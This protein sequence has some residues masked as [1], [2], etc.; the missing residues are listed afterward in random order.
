[1]PSIHL[2][3]DSVI[4]KIAAGEVVDRPASVIRELVENAIDSGATSITVNITDGGSNLIQVSDNG[5]GMERDD[6]VMSIERHATSK[7]TSSGDLMKIST[8]G[9]RGE[10]LATI[11][12]VSKL[13]IIT[14]K[15]SANLGTDTLGTVV[16]IQ[17]GKLISVKD[18]AAPL[19]TEIT[20][21]NL[22]FNTPARKKFLKSDNIETAKIKEWLNSTALAHPKVS[23]KFIVDGTDN[24]FFQSEELDFARMKKLIKGSTVDI[25]AAIPGVAIQGVIGHPL[26]SQSLLTYVTTLV[27][28]RVVSDKGVVR[29]LRDGFSTMLKPG[30]NPVGVINIAVRPD[31]V[32]VNVHP[33]KSEVRFVDARAVYDCIRNAVS[34]ALSEIKSG[35]AVP[36]QQ[37]Q[38]QVFAPAALAARKVIEKTFVLTS[39]VDSQIPA[40]TTANQS[41]IDPIINILPAVKLESLE[42]QIKLSP[43]NTFFSS[44]R[45]IGQLF[46]CY[47]LCE[48]KIPEVEKNHPDIDRE[49]IIVDMHAAHERVNFNIVRQ[50]LLEKKNLLSQRLL[51]PLILSLSEERIS[52]LEEVKDSILISGFEFQIKQ[53]QIIFTAIP[54]IVPQSKIQE[55]ILSI[56]NPENLQTLKAPLEIFIDELAARIACHASVRSGDSMLSQ[57]AYALFDK[58]DS[59]ECGLACPHGRPVYW[60]CSKKEVEQWFGR[61]EA[62]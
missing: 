61:G 21:R 46:S 13:T 6:A 27:N 25:N 37:V 26:T 47:L 29:A 31:L 45:Y 33:Q 57:E 43:K 48:R 18:A 35:S 54:S 55:L 20:V 2:L 58:L 17:G 16:L 50:R 44:L 34:A 5:S 9:F 32:D 4:N 7:I 24:F 59:A 3:S 51:L 62:R 10:A 19:G 41:Y 30:E 38:K 39:K 28:G 1:M 36:M 52:I 14:R 15:S 53:N 60:R 42:T 11:A 49:F 22:F 56:T 12:A 8:L 23:F 40:V